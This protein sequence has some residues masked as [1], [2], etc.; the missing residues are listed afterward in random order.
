MHVQQY[1][2]YKTITWIEEKCTVTESH[3]EDRSVGT[4]TIYYQGF[5]YIH[6]GGGSMQLIILQTN[7]EIVLFLY[8]T[9]YMVI[10]PSNHQ[11]GF[12]R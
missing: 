8:S 6:L 10:K 2:E 12:H 5:I 7:I 1:S 4:L 9:M 3:F 11:T